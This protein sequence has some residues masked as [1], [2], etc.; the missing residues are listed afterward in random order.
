VTRDNGK[1]C[2]PS[3]QF[4]PTGP[5]GVIDGLSAVLKDL[6]ISDYAKLNWLTRVNPSLDILLFACDEGLLILSPQNSFIKHAIKPKAC[7]FRAKLQ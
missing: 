6:E 2:F 3:W 1:L 4:D 5:D 7:N